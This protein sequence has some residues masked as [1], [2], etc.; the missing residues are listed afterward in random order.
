MSDITAGHHLARWQGAT[1]ERLD[2][3][4]ASAVR[5]EVACQT[6][7]AKVEGAVAQLAGRVGVLEVAAGQFGVKASLLVAILGTVGGIVGTA[8]ASTVVFLLI[9]AR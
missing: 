4:E 8:V 2:S 6:S 7:N 3:I 1:D 5:I 9:G